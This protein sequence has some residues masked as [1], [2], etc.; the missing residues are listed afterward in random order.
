MQ[1]QENKLEQLTGTAAAATTAATAPEV[2]GSAAA[3]A[4]AVAAA[5]AGAAEAG[6]AT[7]AATSAASGGEAQSLIDLAASGDA[8]SLSAV[9]LQRL[10]RRDENYDGFRLERV[11]VYNWGSFNNNVKS[12]YFGG[13]NVLMTGDNGAGKSSIIDAIT[14]LLYDVKKVVF[15]QAA[16]AE[17]NERNLASYVLGL[18]KNDN[19]SGIKT[20]MGLRSKDKAV[21]SIIMAAFYNRKLDEKVILVQCMVMLKNK[22]APARYY[23]IGDRD[24]N[25]QQD[26]LPVNDMRELGQKLRKI[27]CTRYEHFSEYYAQ[28]QRAFGIEGTKVLD[29]FYKTISMKSI[30]NISDFVRKQMLEDGNGDELVEQ[31]IDRFNDLDASYKSVEEA[32]KQV[33]ALEPI[34]EKGEQY[35]TLQ[36]QIDFLSRCQDGANPYLYQQKAS[37]IKVELDRNVQ[38]M[39]ELEVQ[40]QKIK[41]DL[42]NV[43]TNILSTRDEINRQGGNRGDFLRQS[44]ATEQ[45]ERNRIYASFTNHASL[46]RNLNLDPIEDETSFNRL[47]KKLVAMEEEYKGNLDQYQD[48]IVKKSTEQER[49]Q[50]KI[51]EISSEIKSLE[52]RKNNIPSRNILVRERICQSIGCS[53]NE[54][55]FVGELLQVKN[56]EKGVWEYAIEKVLR[57][58]GLTMLVPEQY[59]RDVVNYVHHNDLQMLLVFERIKE[60]DFDADEGGNRVGNNAFASALSG[61]SGLNRARVTASSLPRKLEI[62]QD[63]MFYNYIKQRLE[64]QYNFVCTEN[65]DEY[66]QERMALMPSGL[67]KRGGRNEKDDR[68]SRNNDYILG[69]TNEEKIAALKAELAQHNSV[70]ANAK[71][72][73]RN[74]RQACSTIQS[75]MAAITRL[76]EIKSFAYIDYK[77]Y[78]EEIARLNAELEEF[79]RSSNIIETL[80]KRLEDYKKEHKV[81]EERR[82]NF[83]KE[84][85]QVENRNNSLRLEYEHAV[86]LGAPAQYLSAEIVAAIEKMRDEAVERLHFAHVNYEHIERIASEIDGYLKRVIKRLKDSETALSEE[87]V[88]LQSKFT[89]TFVVAGRNLDATRAMAW[90]GFKAFLDKLQQDDLPRF[91][92]AFKDKLNR[93]TIEQFGSL[94]AA[95]LSQSRKIKERIADINT[96]MK[97]VDFNPDH[98]IQ[99]VATESPDVE[100]KQFRNDLRNCTSNMLVSEW[101]FAE[102]DRKFHEVKALIDRFKGEVNG[103]DIDGRW[104]KKVTD[105]KQWFEFSASE[106]SRQDDSQV[107]YYEDSGGKSGGQKE[108]LAYTV[109]ASSLAYQY[110]SK[111]R[112]LNEEAP[113]SINNEVVANIEVGPNAATLYHN[114]HDRSYRF[115]I[116]D[117]A[118]GRGSPQSVD[119]A[120]TLFSKFNLQL[121]VATPMQKLDIIEKYVNHVAFVYRDEDTHESTVVNYDLM[122]YIL[123][124]KLKEHLAKAPLRAVLGGN[125]AAATGAGAGDEQS[126]NDPIN[127]LSTDKT[128][129]LVAK[130]DQRIREEQGKFSG[131]TLG[132]NEAPKPT[133]K[134]K[135]SEQ[136][137]TAA[138]ATDDAEARETQ[139]SLFGDAEEAAADTKPEAKAEAKAEANAETKAETKATLK[140]GAGY[141]TGYAQELSAEVIAEHKSSGE[142]FDQMVSTEAEVA[143][144]GSAKLI[145]EDEDGVAV[146]STAEAEADA[147]SEAETETEGKPSS[148]DDKT[149]DLHLKDEFGNYFSPEEYAKKRDEERKQYQQQRTDEALSKLDFLDSLF[150]GTDEAE[151]Q[152]V[153]VVDVEETKPQA[154]SL[155]DEIELGEVLASAQGAEATESAPA[156]KAKSKSKAKK[157]AEEEEPKYTSSLEDLLLDDDEE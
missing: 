91:V 99:M 29:L 40:I 2:A 134:R 30:S 13:Q 63:P 27:G 20:E 70:V 1:E 77:R 125:A 14:V 45:K 148:S 153:P 94:H 115:V 106:H 41:D 3:V 66:R 39:D 69:W 107:D 100:I 46:L 24:F 50:E 64:Q 6:A 67:N 156:P 114:Y 17:K 137:A 21:L 71:A 85:G 78:D 11:D 59:Y 25:L 117:E 48:N 82:D 131:P 96:I 124:R 132:I 145:T 22:S 75:H 120:L 97:D 42:E 133:R 5:D 95:L 119:Y 52:S 23:F 88:N 37:L 143:G 80:E 83:F 93:E 123:K 12:V 110:R 154:P 31:M 54:L 56:E 142:L 18:Y 111:A 122:D 105:V 19:S 62:K 86:D 146:E 65:Q 35:Q 15:N 87:L 138:A 141:T 68:K 38:R 147:E 144:Y 136:A 79:K 139:G 98:Y 76:L 130:L 89:Q 129:E 33:E 43:N 4:A 49:E 36:K 152:V 44:I 81:L 34:C 84:K 104:R 47:N 155:A 103:A 126:G 109:L 112:K 92:E 26:V 55:P 9:D 73:I 57:N 53:E 127:A 60:N 90:E 113:D 157:K 116:I 28:M 101:S 121:L 135:S 16:G 151:D 32:R 74:L 10:A 58:F 7:N 149:E 51:N 102:A 61:M 150:N 128:K 118:F 108:K 140:R 72:T 8:V